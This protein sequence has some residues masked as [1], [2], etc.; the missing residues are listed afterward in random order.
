MGFYGLRR[1]KTDLL[2]KVG[3]HIAASKFLA[4]NTL[5]WFD[6]SG[7]RHIRVHDT[8]VLVMDGDTVVLDSGG[9]RTFL[10]KQRIN[11]HLPK[12]L[13]LQSER[14]VWYVVHSRWIESRKLDQWGGRIGRWKV[15]WK[16]PFYD[17]IEIVNYAQPDLDRAI[18]A[19]NEKVKLKKKIDAY[20]R[21]LK[22][23]DR[24]PEPS[25]GDCLICRIHGEKVHNHGRSDGMYCLEQHLDEKY[26][27]GSLIY[28]ALRWAG[29]KNEQMPFV[30]QAQ[31]IVP[32]VVRRFLKAQLGVV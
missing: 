4:R 10:T 6:T 27:H 20:I 25:N 12:N 2:S 15:Y 23:L 18:E 22:K 26:I 31:W 29:Y 7:R 19:G 28:N 1:T 3:D 16:V 5:E 30:Y 9:W 11:E 21:A 14:G 24:Y 32:R 13:S 17:G 8:D